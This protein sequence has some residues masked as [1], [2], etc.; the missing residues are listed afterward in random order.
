[1]ALVWILFGTLVL[2]G[3]FFVV[4]FAQALGVEARLRRL[5]VE[6]EGRIAHS[7]SLRLV[8][9]GH[10]AESASGPKGRSQAADPDASESDSE[11]SGEG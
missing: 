10:A 1:V 8:P 6:T 5:V 2:A 9:P 3:A 7:Y 4:C 11:E